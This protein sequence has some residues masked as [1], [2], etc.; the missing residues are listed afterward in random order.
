MKRARLVML[1]VICTGVVGCKMPAS[2]PMPKG[3]AEIRREVAPNSS[4]VASLM[5]H[6]GNLNSVKEESGRVGADFEK[7]ISASGA[8][9]Q[10]ILKEFVTAL[11]DLSHR[12]EKTVDELASLKPPSKYAEFQKVFVKTQKELVVIGLS[13]ADAIE[14]GNGEKVQ[15]LDAQYNAAE[16][17]GRKEVETVVRASGAKSLNDFLGIE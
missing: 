15:E 13:M 11:R 12:T 14:S 9:R 10:E 1:G 17:A 5:F 3:E 2:V 4:Y 16:S 8:D 7:R 6:L